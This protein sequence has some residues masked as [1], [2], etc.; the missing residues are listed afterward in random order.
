MQDKDIKIIINKKKRKLIYSKCPT[1]KRDDQKISILF[2]INKSGQIDC[3]HGNF[4]D[5]GVEYETLLCNGCETIF[6]QTRSWNSEDV[7][8]DYGPDNN[9]VCTF[10]STER[11]FHEET[12]FTQSIRDFQLL[13]L[14]IQSIYNETKT[15][16][17]SAQPI[18]A[19]IG[20]R[21]ILEII[22]KSK[23]AIGRTLDLKINS[24]VS[25]GALSLNGAKVL[26][27]LRILGNAAAHDAK[28]HS[29]SQ[30]SSAIEVLDSLL[31][32]VYI[33]EPQS[34]RVFSSVRKPRKKKSR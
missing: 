17:N 2:S 5:W 34:R 11:I 27:K 7:D 21:A 8:Y 30:L 25:K 1:C 22:C 18:L 13:P 23:R 28:P 24:L 15:A 19:G 6:F 31:L 9:P 32:T 14:Q 33:L 29:L 4:L 26:H 12:A 20:I 3:G 16:L 10:N